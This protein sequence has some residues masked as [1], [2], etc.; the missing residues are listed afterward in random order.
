MQINNFIVESIISKRNFARNKK[1]IQRIK[2]RHSL[3]IILANLN[4][5]FL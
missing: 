3:V 1:F 4:V 2:F 5:K